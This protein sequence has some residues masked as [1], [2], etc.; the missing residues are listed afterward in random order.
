MGPGSLNYRR[1]GIKPGF[2]LARIQTYCNV[3][4][5]VSAPP[6]QLSYLQMESVTCFNHFQR[7]ISIDTR[8][9]YIILLDAAS[10][11]TLSC[12]CRTVEVQ[13]LIE[14]AITGQR[15]QNTTKKFFCPMFPWQT[16]PMITHSIMISP[17]RKHTNTTAHCH[18]TL[19]LSR[20]VQSAV[21]YLSPAS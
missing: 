9:L 20:G 17:R 3:A 7:T 6:T 12:S 16:S 18:L 15:R 14:L 10:A 13:L 19:C 1:G 2:L 11:T 5:L 8:P 21:A 4:N